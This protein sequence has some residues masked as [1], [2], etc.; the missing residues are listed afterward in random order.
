[1]CSDGHVL[2]RTGWFCCSFVT[3]VKVTCW[4]RQGSGGG[5]VSCLM[6]GTG[7][8]LTVGRPSQPPHGC[9]LRFP[10]FVGVQVVILAVCF[11]EEVQNSFRGYSASYRSAG[12]RAET[13]HGQAE[14]QGTGQGSLWQVAYLSWELPRFV[15]R[16]TVSAF[17]MW[18]ENM[19][20]AKPPRRCHGLCTQSVC[21]V[22]AVRARCCHGERRA[23]LST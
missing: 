9:S 15:H 17:R 3:K 19:D 6:S 21:T 14:R 22:I 10:C 5:I 11:Q 2:L 20:T 23:S 13:S 18:A 7:T 12:R 8:V 4:A 1:M 16:L